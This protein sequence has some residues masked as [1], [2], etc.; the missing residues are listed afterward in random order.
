MVYRGL[1]SYR[2]RVR[3]ITRFPNMFFVLCFQL[4]RHIYFVIFDIVGS[5]LAWSVLLS[6]TIRVITVVKML[7]THE[8]QQIELHHKARALL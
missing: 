7:W 2:K 6:T 8:A 4:S 1:Y 3:V 5:L